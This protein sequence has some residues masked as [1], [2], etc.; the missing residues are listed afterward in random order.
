M[1]VFSKNSKLQVVTADLAVR[2]QLKKITE[3]SQKF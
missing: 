2:Y 3:I 1:K